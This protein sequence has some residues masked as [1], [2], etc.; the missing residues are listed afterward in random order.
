MI[1]NWG[2]TFKEGAWRTL[3]GFW[4]TALSPSLIF[5]RLGM[6]AGLI[7]SIGIMEYWNDALRRRKRINKLFPF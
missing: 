5:W 7:W 2:E 3:L 1:R 4:G 6:M